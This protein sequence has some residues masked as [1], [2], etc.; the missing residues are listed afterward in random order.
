M[1]TTATVSGS[2]VLGTLGAMLI[3]LAA[4][5]VSTAM[6][7]WHVDKGVANYRQGYR[8]G[9]EDGRTIQGVSQMSR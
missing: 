3:V 6:V 9:L 4:V 2:R 5:G 8:D 1:L 7:F